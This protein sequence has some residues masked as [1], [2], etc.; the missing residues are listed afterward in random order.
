[1]HLAHNTDAKPKVSISDVTSIGLIPCDTRLIALWQVAECKDKSK[2]CSWRLARFIN[3]YFKYKGAYEYQKPHK[4]C[5]L[6]STTL[7]PQKNLMYMSISPPN[8][9]VRL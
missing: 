6:H 2:A 5:Y 9:L 8:A 1:M 4:E 3:L 7:V